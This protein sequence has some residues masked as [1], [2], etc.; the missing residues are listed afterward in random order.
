[1]VIISVVPPKVGQITYT[2]AFTTGPRCGSLHRFDVVD[3][4][5]PYVNHGPKLLW[6]APPHDQ[7]PSALAHEIAA[8]AIFLRPLET[9][10]LDGEP[11]DLAFN[12]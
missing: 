11:E 3:P 5:S 9:K 10:L 4:L 7:H 2:V 1:M 8:E 6:I 12:C